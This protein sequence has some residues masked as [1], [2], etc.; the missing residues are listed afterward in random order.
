MKTESKDLLARAVAIIDVWITSD[1]LTVEHIRECQQR[2]IPPHESALLTYTQVLM[3]N[4]AKARALLVEYKKLHPDEEKPTKKNEK[5]AKENAT[6]SKNNTAVRKT[7]KATG[8]G[9]KDGG[10]G[11]NTR[12]AKKQ[13]S[14]RRNS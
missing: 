3:G 10:V 14:K 6:P 11:T 4:K 1:D 9:K 8:A 5:P 2:G 13:I 7:K 12:R